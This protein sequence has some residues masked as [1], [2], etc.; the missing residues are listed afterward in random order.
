[1]DDFSDIDQFVDDLFRAKEQQAQANQELL[2]GDVLGGDWRNDRI[3]QIIQDTYDDVI[4]W[5]N[6]RI[7]EGTDPESG[8]H[9]LPHIPWDERIDGV[10]AMMGAVGY[11]DP[12][13]TQV[14]DHRPPWE[15]AGVS[16][17]VYLHSLLTELQREAAAARAAAPA[18][19]D[20]IPLRRVLFVIAAVLAV[21]TLITVILSTF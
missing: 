7:S 15:I 19:P 11:Y 3:D 13:P 8:L 2:Y 17:E 4:R 1:M 5:H 14:G 16:E 18:Q 10:A 21:M 9:G 20:E 6:Q 12:Q